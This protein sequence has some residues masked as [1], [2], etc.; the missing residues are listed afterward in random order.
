MTATLRYILI[1]LGVALA[2]LGIWYFFNIVAYVLISAVLALIGR[3]LVDLLGHLR[4][5]KVRLPRWSRALM[6]LLIIWGGML[7]LVRIFIPLIISEVNNLSTLNPDK[8][9]DALDEPIRTVENFIDRYQLAGTETFTVEEFLTQKAISVLNVSFLSN[10]FS[11]FAGIL[12]NMFIAF[13]SI[14]FITFFFLRDEKLFAEAILVLVPD[15]HVESF[16]HAM[17]S[18][19]MLLMRYFIG[20]LAQISG[21]FTLVT[22]G[23]TIV[24][25]GFGHSLLIGL[26][27]ALFNVIPYLGPLIGSS[28]GIALGIATHIDLQFTTELLP[29]ILKMIGVFVVVQITDNLVF[30]PFIFSNS[31]SAHPLEIFLVILMAGSLGGIPGMILAIPL[32][33]V[34]RVFLKEFFSNFKVVKK[35][36]KNIR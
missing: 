25:V 30:Q 9:I 7:I 32:Y 29:L 10:M 6:T 4:I 11:S 2:L 31:V 15:K 1:A 20:I 23:L 19:R 8:I 21:I 18:V 16:R 22:V 36:T 28:I 24:G 26:I 5:R 3:P 27:A 13:F 17:N 35:L 14:S 12:G 33:T 34:L